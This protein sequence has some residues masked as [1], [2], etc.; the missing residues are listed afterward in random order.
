MRWP[1]SACGNH[2]AGALGTLTPLPPLS[3]GT[4][5]RGPS[6]AAIPFGPIEAESVRGIH[7]KVHR[8]LAQ[9]Q[10]RWI[11]HPRSD[12][13]HPPS[14]L[15]KTGKAAVNDAVGPRISCVG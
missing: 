4:P 3:G 15:G 11:V 5:P 12:E 1:E 10:R 7:L 9:Q 2:T 8:V 14:S 6:K 13:N